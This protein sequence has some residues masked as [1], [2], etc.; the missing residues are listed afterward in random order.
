[1]GPNNSTVA[2][3][4]KVTS[5]S[6]ELLIYIP[7]FVHNDYWSADVTVKN[8]VLTRSYV[9]IKY[10]SNYVMDMIKAINR[11]TAMSSS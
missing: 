10:P 9:Y 11:E 4:C 8:G 5:Y 1:M 7:G 6:L 3:G 2:K